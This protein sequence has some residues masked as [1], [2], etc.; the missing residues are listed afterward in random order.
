MRAPELLKLAIDWLR[1]TYPQSIIVPEMSVSDWGGAMI[2]VAAITDE[3]IVGIE[4]KGEGDSPTRLE[5]QG[6]KYGQVARR[7]WLLPTPEGTLAARCDKKAHPSWGR[8]ELHEGAVRPRNIATKLGP[9]EEDERGRKGRSR[10]P[11]PDRYNF[12]KPGLSRMLNPW[13]ICGTL[14]REELYR[15]AKAQGMP[16]NSKTNVGP[17][18]DMLVKSL[19]VERLHDLMIEQLR[20]RVWR[21]AVIDTRD[22]T[23]P[24]QGSLLDG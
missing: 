17:L 1:E 8:L 4:I 5:L 12:S 9:W 13:A 20:Q 21:K 16:V 18:T 11:D 19:P 6:Q 2:D 22:P 15:I 7:M 24:A 3:M 10:I 23:P 14:W